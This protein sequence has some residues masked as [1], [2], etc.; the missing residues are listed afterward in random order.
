MNLIK[1]FFRFLFNAGGLVILFTLLAC[2]GIPL[3]TLNRI[4]DLHDWAF[5]EDVEDNRSWRL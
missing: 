5:G 3:W 4:I 1:A 2:I